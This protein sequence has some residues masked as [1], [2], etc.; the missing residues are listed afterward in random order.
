MLLEAP[1][2][3]RKEAAARRAQGTQPRCVRGPRPAGV[4][5]FS[6]PSLVVNLATGYFSDFSF[7]SLLVFD[8]V[9]YSFQM[10]TK[11]N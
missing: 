8:Q 5:G 2:G 11:Y 4:Q 9:I 6:L 10:V 7:G 1:L 3:W